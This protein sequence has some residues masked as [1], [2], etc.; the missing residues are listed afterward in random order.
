MILNNAYLLTLAQDYHKNRTSIC[1][2]VPLYHCLGMVMASLATICHGI[3]CV[4]PYPTFNAEES[5]K[6]IQNEK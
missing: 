5:L 6:S 4:L 2:Q 1:L 3:T